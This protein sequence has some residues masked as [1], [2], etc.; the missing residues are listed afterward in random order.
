MRDEFNQPFE[1]D[2]S[3]EYYIPKEYDT[4]AKELFESVKEE[5]QV[6]QKKSLTYQ[7][8][9]M[10]YL[11]SAVLSVG[12]LSNSIDPSF[13]ILEGIGM[14]KNDT[15]MPVVEGEVEDEG[16]VGVDERPTEPT[17]TPTATPTAPVVEPGGEE[18]VTFPKLSNLEPNG[19]VPGYGVL[20][21]EFVYMVVD[22]N[23]TY[24]HAGE[25]Y[26]MDDVSNIPGAS[27]D[28]STN[29]LTLNNCHA[30]YLNVNLMGNGFTIRLV[31]DNYVDE[32]LV[33]GFIYGGSVTFTGDGSL[34][35]LGNGDNKLG[36][37]LLAE[38]SESCIMV[39]EGV[40]LDISGE[41]A[42]VLVRDTNEEK[43]LYCKNP[44]KLAG[45]EWKAID[46]KNGFTIYSVVDEAGNYAKHVVI[47]K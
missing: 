1:Y 44:L 43:G 45:G 11:V 12:V 28:E 33:W 37:C 16:D 25:A 2:C 29:V 32:I 39:D 4:S 19:F 46:T 8:R 34:T 6:E 7:I 17:A 24:L 3:Q 40:T 36:L 23:T 15:G 5:G 9:K 10:V 38:Q 20:D 27:Y 47:S 13:S 41:D 30:S 42:A 31:G 35:M 14:A 26:Q 22:G 18:L 21:E